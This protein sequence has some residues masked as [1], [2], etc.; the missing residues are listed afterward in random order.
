MQ[1]WNPECIYR[2]KLSES[3]KNGFAKMAQHRL[4]GT[5]PGIG[6]V[7]DVMS[8]D[9]SSGVILVY[10]DDFVTILSKDEE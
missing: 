9:L 5:I 6:E 10:G 7:K 2:G 1:M 8:F 3:V 4:S